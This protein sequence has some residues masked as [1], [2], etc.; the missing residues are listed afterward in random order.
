MFVFNVRMELK[1]VWDVGS[2]NEVAQ[3][4]H[5]VCA[6]LL[7]VV[8]NCMYVVVARRDTYFVNVCMG[9]VFYF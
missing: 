8:L 6:E 9:W 7:D 2:G 4:C 3:C 1:C 5:S